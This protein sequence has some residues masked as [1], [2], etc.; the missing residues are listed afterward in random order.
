M[1]SFNILYLHRLP[2]FS[3]IAILRTNRFDVLG[4]PYLHNAF[5]MSSGKEF[6]P[7]VAV[8]VGVTFGSSDSDATASFIVGS[9][10]E[11]STDLFFS[12]EFGI[13]ITNSFT[14]F[15]GGV[16]LYH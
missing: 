4:V 10:I 16:V 6:D 12:V 3:T 1:C 15:S 14:Y 13:E 2:I 8:P 5:E 7:Y 11:F 9:L